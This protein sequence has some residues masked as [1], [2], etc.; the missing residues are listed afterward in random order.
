VHGLHNIE[1]DR[2]RKNGRQGQDLRGLASCE[3]NLNERSGGL[4]RG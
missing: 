2:R 3:L 4:E 1:T